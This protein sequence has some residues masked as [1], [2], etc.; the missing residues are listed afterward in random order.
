MDD[1]TSVDGVVRDQSQTGARI[2]CDKPEI[3]PDEFRLIVTK[4]ATIQPCTVRWRAREQL[5]VSYD[6]EPKP[7]PP[8]KF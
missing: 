7:A 5:G 6:G 3:V 4:E 1:W 2:A 8:R